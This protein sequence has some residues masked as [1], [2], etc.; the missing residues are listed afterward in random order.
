MRETIPVGNSEAPLL[1]IVVPTYNES[2]RLPRTLE[3]VTAYFGRQSYRWELLISDDGSRDDTVT[4]AN[5]VARHWPQM[6]VLTA[7]KNRGKGAAVRRG[8]L[9]ATG[10]YVLFSDADLATPIEDVEKLLPLLQDGYDVVIGSRAMPD[11][12]ILTKQPLLRQITGKGFRQV[13]RRLAVQGLRDTQCGFKAFRTPA[14]RHIFAQLRTERFAFDVEALLLAEALGYPIKEVGVTWADQPGTTVAPLRDA[15]TMWRDVYRLRRGVHHR[16]RDD[17]QSVPGEN[18]RCIGLVTVRDATGLGDI[19]VEQLLE[20]D[21]HADDTILVVREQGTATLATFGETVAATREA[22]IEI[23]AELTS[24]RATTGESAAITEELQVLPL[25]TP[26]DWLR[27]SGDGVT[28]TAPQSA[29][30]ARMRLE[31]QAREADRRAFEQRSQEWR[32]R[33]ATVRVLTAVNVVGLVWW[34]MWLYDYSHAANFVL[35]TLLVVAESF[36]VLQ[37]L[38]YWFTVWNERPPERRRVKVPGRVDVFITTYNESVELVENTVRAAVSMTYPHRTYVLD[39]GNRPEMGEMAR[40]HGA[41]WITRPD[42][43]GAKAGNINHALTQTSG[44]FFVIFDADHVPHPDF[45]QRLMPY[46]DDPKMAFVQAPQFYVN[47]DRTYVAGGAMDQQELFFGPICRGKDGMNAVFCCGT[48]VVLRRSAIADVGGFDEHSITEDAVTSV[49]LHERGWHSRYVDERVAEGLGPDDL[50]AYIS[51]QRRWARGNI[52]MLF[53]FGIFR[54]KMSWK[55]RLQY[56]WSAM[57]YLTG[58]TVP[59]YFVL[60]AAF[61]LFGWQAVSAQSGN[62]IAHFLPY[63]FMTIY[64]LTRSAEGRLRFRAIQFSYGLFPVFLSA[65]FSVLTG[66]RAHFQVT[67][68]VGRVQSFYHLIIPQIA[69]ALFLVVAIVFGS[70]HFSGARTVTNA[71]WALFDLV[72][73]SGIIRAAAPQRVS[74]AEDMPAAADAARVGTLSL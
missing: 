2:R 34:L 6:R 18:D 67:P 8:I 13:V 59:L 42:N 57:Y 49:K 39:D 12:N 11:S 65:L 45:L 56:A 3:Q 58:L 61:L 64:I 30:I 60:P 9:A 31:D 73:I 63:I 40:R 14:G 44:E 48:N 52:E 4:I 16:L 5:E 38:G 17:I 51:Q 23:A 50:S 47:R 41:E 70:L 24:A 54:R 7:T 10:R 53:K 28:A 15:W 33:R 35:Y 20:S 68:K 62:F 37:V 1:S 74:R 72:L 46:M 32:R 36:S 21:R 71:S 22:G 29:V 55:L 26:I 43:Q 66:K 25:A 69:F 19:A 27:P